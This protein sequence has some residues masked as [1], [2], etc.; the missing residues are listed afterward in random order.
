MPGHVAV[1]INYIEQLPE[2]NSLKNLKGAAHLRDEIEAYYIKFVMSYF[3]PENK[4][5][6]KLKS[7]FVE[8]FRTA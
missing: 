8:A 2:Y 4:L 1:V 5:R 6:D 3:D 7:T